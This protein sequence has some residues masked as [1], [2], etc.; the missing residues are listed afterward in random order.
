MDSLE[1]IKCDFCN[2][3]KSHKIHVG[4]KFQENF[5]YVKCSNCGLIYLNPRPTRNDI[6]KY[7]PDE[8]GPYQKAVKEEGNI[9]IR[10]MRRRNVSKKR[11]WI[12]KISNIKNGEILDIGCSTGN[13]LYEMK[14]NGWS[15]FGVEISET[16]SK[17]AQTKLNLNVYKGTLE[18]YYLDAKQEFFDVITFW[19]VL[20]HTYSPAKQLEISSKLLQNNGLLIIN[21]PNYNSID[22]QLFKGNWVGYDPP[23]HLY[24]FNPK[25]IEDYLRKYGFNIILKKCFISSY[26]S[27]IISVENYFL[28][29]NSVIAKKI[30]KVL[31]IPG[32]RFIFEPVL[33]IFNLFGFGTIITI[34]AKK[35]T[36][37]EE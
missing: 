27:F 34:F 7:Y 30:K 5:Q 28:Q 37:N 29:K 17:Y 25:L 26:Y 20:E 19:D 11:K 35:G 24:V 32:M 14:M 4:I 22:H 3:E 31:L 15:T 6:L 12:E 13:F 18:E 36:T 8:Y 2:S 9:L 10:F 21:I 1:F 33:K 23:R 16:A